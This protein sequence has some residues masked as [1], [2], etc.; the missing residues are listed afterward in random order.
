MGPAEHG[1]PPPPRLGL[2]A[3]WRQFTLLV[4]INGFVGSMVGLE[5][6]TLPLLAEH[7]FAL[8]SRTAIL[9]FIVSFGIVKALTNLIAGVAGDRLGRRYVLIAGWL[10]WLPVPIL[11]MVAPSWDW[12]VFA[13]VLLGI[14]QGL[15][16]STTVIM[17]IDLVGPARRGLALGLNEA[18]G[19]LAVSAAAL[20]SGYLAAAHGLRPAPYLLGIGFALAGLALSAGF[21]RE[22]HGHARYESHLVDAAAGGPGVPARR[23]AFLHVLLLTSWRERA[24]SAASQA[25][26]VNNLNDG[27]AWGLLPLLFAGAGLPVDQI[28]LLA[29]VYP[30]VWGVTQLGTG[31]LSDRLGRKG[32]IVAGMWVQAGAI[33]LLIA[34]PGFEPWLIALALLGLGT[35]LVYPTLLAVVSDVAHPAWRASAVGVYRL[36]RDSGYAVG[37]LLAGSLA[38][39]LGV[40]W[41]I[42]V[43]G[44]LTF[45]AGL[46]V[47]TRMYET[48]PPKPSSTGAPTGPEGVETRVSTPWL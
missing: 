22:S 45:V 35:A 7:D 3:N 31:A 4:V 11:I 39:R 38:D 9:S 26:L 23:P 13:N 21:A 8:A 10:V 19:Y 29:A 20:A 32:M 24:L 48:L 25:G 18:A 34:R 44:A 6:A 1:P 30:G 5:R 2:R 42:G 28:G 12:V 27:M 16:W 15:C 14:N 40:T 43:I 37:A 47:L 41:A 36:W 17:K 33:F 46:V